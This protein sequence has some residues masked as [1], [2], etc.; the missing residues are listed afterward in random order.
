MLNRAPK[1]LLALLV[2]ASLS[3]CSNLLF[4]IANAPTRFA[5]YQRASAVSYGSQLR[6]KLDV[7]AL[8][9]ASNAPVVVFW[10]GGSFERGERQQYRFVGAAL[11]EAGLVAVL[12]DY[13]VY[14]AARFPEF[15]QDAAAAVRWVRDNV[16]SHG[17]DP[18]RIFLMGHSAG[19]YLATLVALDRR[20]LQQAGVGDL[21]LRGVI[22]LSGPHVLTPNTA[23]L[24]QIFAPPWRLAD[25]QPVT[26]ANPL[27]PPM[28]LIHGARDTLVGPE[29]SSRLAEALGSAGASV[30]L[31][32]LAD[33][34]HA[35]TVASISRIARRRGPVL[36]KVI[37]FVRQRSAN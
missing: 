37:E 16:Q 26:Y 3:G 36:E 22:A 17:G 32:I 28:L 10:Y 15:A 23:A 14:P 31:E 35:D 25:W 13:R 12:P 4:G 6:Q 30:Q 9:T 5:A 1:L 29:Q 8:R 2:A 20:Y 34:G 27:A 33:A 11:A 21:T 24:N 7:Y 18:A 19:A